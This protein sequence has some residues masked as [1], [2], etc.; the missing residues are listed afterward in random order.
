[1]PEHLRA[2]IIILVLATTFF[3]F[4]RYP[5]SAI[6]EVENFTRRRNLWLGLTLAVFL[7]HNFWIYVIIAIL[8]LLYSNRRESNPPALFFSILLV[9]PMAIVQIPGMGMINYIFDLSHARILSLFI[10]LPAFFTLLWQVDT[11]AF[12]RTGPDKLLAAYL[13]LTSILLLREDNITN[14]MRQIFYLFID[15]FLPYFV[16]SRSL[17]NLQSFRDALLSLVLAIMVLAPLAVFESA[18]HWLLYSSLTEA[19]GLEEGMTTYLGRDGLLR[20]ITTAGQPIALGYLMAVGMGLYL[21]LQSAIKQKFVRRLGMVLLI[22]GL[23][24]PVSRGPWVGAAVLIVVFIATGPYVVRRLMSLALAAILALPLIAML[25]G[26]ERVINLLPFIG[27]TEKG[28]IDYRERL[29][30]NSMIVIQRNPWFGSDDFLNTPEMEVMRQ[31]EGI[32]DIVNTYI[33]IALKAGLV[34]L[35]LFVGF[36][37]LT[38]WA[39]CRAMRSIPDK[40]SEEYLLGRALLATL[41]AILTII[42]TVSSITIIPIVYWSVAGLG[43]AYAQMVR[44]NAA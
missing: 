38:L 42:T 20:A 4:A 15:V 22:V 1:M 8:L 37:A 39:I 18:K 7:A 33:S 35:G 28:G 32:I 3:A 11:A 29:I 34:G 23:I 41:L 43:V 13:L 2:L 40:D 5:A 9:L 44:K 27:T 14:T 16:I 19:L 10:L 31:G 30:T 17:K 36:F 26:G 21:F 24:A 25:P 12:G 6:T